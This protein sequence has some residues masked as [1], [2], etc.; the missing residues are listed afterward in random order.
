M[1]ETRT[2]KY[3]ACIS[4]SSSRHC[5]SLLVDAFKWSIRLNAWWSV[6]LTKKDS[7]KWERDTTLRIVLPETPFELYYNRFPHR[8]KS[9]AMSGWA[10]GSLLPALV[11][12]K[13]QS[14][15][16]VRLSQLLTCHSV[17]AGLVLVEWPANP[18]THLPPCIPRRQ[19]WIES[20]RLFFLQLPAYWEGEAC[21]IW[22]KS[23][24]NV[25]QARKQLYFWYSGRVLWRLDCFCGFLIH[26]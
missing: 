5:T 11:A 23:L 15:C 18:S 17:E 1:I 25:T 13:T 24:Q 19:I 9:G 16:H 6:L 14:W 21:K 10:S 4:I 12:T 26:L 2:L 3:L 7:S 8:T 20:Q 22:Y